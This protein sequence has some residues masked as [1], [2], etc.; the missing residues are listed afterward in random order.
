MINYVSKCQILLQYSKNCANEDLRHYCYKEH[1]CYKKGKNFYD[2][3]WPWPLRYGSPTKICTIPGVFLTSVPKIKSIRPLILEKFEDTHTDTHTNR[4]L[5]AIIV[6]MHLDI[7]SVKRDKTHAVIPLYVGW[8]SIWILII[9]FIF[10][11]L[12]ALNMVGSYWQ[13]LVFQRPH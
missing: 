6:Y 11:L 1:Y 10:S 7:C 9:H 8:K 3:W 13:T 2:L 5:T 12:W 4:R